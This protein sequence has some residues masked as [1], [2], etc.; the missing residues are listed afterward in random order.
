M[1]KKVIHFTHHDLDGLSC[2]VIVNKV[3]DVVKFYSQGYGKVDQRMDQCINEK[4]DDVNNIIIT[5]LKMSDESL[6]KAIQAFKNV[7]Y[8][9]HHLDSVHHEKYASKNFFYKYDHMKSATQL[10]YDI[11]IHN[12]KND[13]SEM[14]LFTNLINSYDLWLTDNK[15][16]TH[17]VLL[18][19]L[20]WNIE[21]Q[22]YINFF[23]NGMRKLT[24][25]YMKIVKEKH[26]QREST[27]ENAM[28]KSLDSGS[29]IVL[30]DSATAI[31]F[32]PT[33]Y[34]GDV[35]YI[36][37]INRHGNNALSGRVA[38]HSNVDLNTAF[39]IITKENPDIVK[40]AGGHA[41][42]AGITL[43]D[44]FKFNYIAQFI[45]EKVDPAVRY[46]N[47]TDNGFE[48]KDDIPF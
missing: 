32:V 48:F 41:H 47:Q 44:N 20:M 14:K 16:F 12:K 46:Y 8:L 42:A 10:C 39:G 45:A 11:F 38:A 30:L 19:D 2:A 40:S 18:N 43:Q 37:Y 35:F 9:D 29:K 4:P 34:E 13:S 7:I 1:K 25:D 27:L 21:P 15:E 22:E 36:M 3:F 33:H 5:D 24:N 17:G 31:N 28:V 26:D 6:L 23:S